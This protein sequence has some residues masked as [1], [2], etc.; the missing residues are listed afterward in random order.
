M[1]PIVLDGISANPMPETSEIKI[2]SAD[3]PRLFSFWEIG[4]GVVVTLNT[5]SGLSK[6]VLKMAS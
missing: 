4:K 5:K 1:F 2:A 6:A 3:W